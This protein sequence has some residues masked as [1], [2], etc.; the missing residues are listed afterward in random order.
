MT[1]GRLEKGGLLHA[2]K[3]E[4]E[5]RTR[6]VVLLQPNKSLDFIEALIM[7]QPGCV[8]FPKTSPALPAYWTALGGQKIF[9]TS[10]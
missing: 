7:S 6:V 3:F 9:Q 5:T 10:T 2:A 1:G 4:L 8:F